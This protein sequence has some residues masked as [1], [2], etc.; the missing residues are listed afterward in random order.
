LEA[1]GNCATTLNPN[2]SRFVKFITLGFNNNAALCSAKVQTFLLD[3]ERLTRRNELESTFHVFHYLWEGADENRLKFDAIDKPF[4]NQ[5]NGTEDRNAIKTGWT[6]LIDALKK[7]RISDIHIEGITNVLGAIFHLIHSGATNNLAS[8]S[9]FI[10]TRNAQIAAELLG[11]SFDQLN[12]A[13]F[14]GNQ[15]QPEMSRFD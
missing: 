11:V 5:L 8:R 6:R 14:R 9:S 4:I 2:A 1:F 3:T 12:L 15:Q 13:V 10:R 7:L